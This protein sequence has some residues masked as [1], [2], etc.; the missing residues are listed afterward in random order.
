MSLLQTKL[1]WEKGCLQ[2][3]CLFLQLCQV[4]WVGKGGQQDWYSVGITLL[5]I[6]IVLL[7]SNYLLSSFPSPVDIQHK[8]RNKVKKKVKIKSTEHI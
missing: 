1:L 4:P 6:S 8:T 5:F 2:Q 7:A 3:N